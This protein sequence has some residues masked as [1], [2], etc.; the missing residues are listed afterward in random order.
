VQSNSLPYDDYTLWTVQAKPVQLH[1]VVLSCFASVV[2][3]FG[4]FLA[5]AIKRAYNIKDFDALIP[6]HGGFMDR[7]DCQFL[8]LL[9]T[10]VHYCTFVKG[11]LQEEDLLAIIGVMPPAQKERFVQQLLASLNST[12]TCSH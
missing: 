2:A 6:G 4:G 7:M 8:M 9:C 10:Y 11:N 12:M 3:P 5:S 1:A